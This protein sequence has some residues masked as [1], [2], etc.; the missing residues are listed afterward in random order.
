MMRPT[1]A[2]TVLAAAI[3][4]LA[5]A[6]PNN[7]DTHSFAAGVIHPLSGID[8]TSVMALVGVWG[9][10][11][12]GRAIWAWPAIFIVAM[13]SGFAA[14]AWGPQLGFVEPAIAT[15][16]VL[17]GLFAALRIRLP[18]GLGGAVV[19]L[20][21]VF[22]GH[23]HGTEAAGADLASYAAGF[24]L[25]TASLHVAGIAIGLSIRRSL[26]KIAGERKRFGRRTTSSVSRGELP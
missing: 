18:I 13:L 11:V 19:G 7:G 24:T 14:A 16:I 6:H 23:V 12:G 15:S 3:L 22:H 8:H 5:F 2:C 20:F 26:E 4:V 25:S 9:A 21:A 17:L 10:L 1:L